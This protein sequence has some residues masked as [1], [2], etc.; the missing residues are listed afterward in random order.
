MKGDKAVTQSSV[1]E[2]YGT[3]DRKG[4]HIKGQVWNRETAAKFH[5]N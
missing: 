4:G 5:P 1:E 2:D 3:T